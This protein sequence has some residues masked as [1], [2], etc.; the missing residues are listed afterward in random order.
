MKRVFARGFCLSLSV[1]L[2]GVVALFN[3]SAQQVAM[4]EKTPDAVDYYNRG[5][6]CAEADF[7]CRIENF[8]RAVEL[9]PALT[10]AYNNRGLAFFARN[11]TARALADF[12]RTV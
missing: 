10:E 9:D 12:N 1:F 3:V 8:S 4:L 11:E 7:D 5:C 6:A 2:F